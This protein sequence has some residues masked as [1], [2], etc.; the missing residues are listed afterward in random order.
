MKQK[1]EGQKFHIP[2]PFSSEFFMFLQHGVSNDKEVDVYINEKK[3]FA[4]LYPPRAIDY[5]TYESRVKKLNLQT[6]KKKNEVYEKRFVKLVHLFKDNVASLLEVGAAEGSFL[7][8]IKREFPQMDVSAVEP[9][10]STLASRQEIDGIKTYASIEESG[11]IGKRFD[12]IC[13]FHVFEHIM[14]PVKFLNSIKKL[15]HQNTLLIIEVP[16]LFDPLLTL[17]NCLSYKSF[18]FQIQ[19]PYVYSHTSLPRFM[20]YNGFQTQE[21]INFQRYGIENH[22]N[23]LINNAPGGNELYR[24]IF[25]ETNKRYI[26]ELEQ[27]GKTDTV[28]WVGKVKNKC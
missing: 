27:S 12:V 16:S 25:V 20:D 14:D 9:D 21:V 1:I 24:N 28:I 8:I 6:Y 7:F 10:A 15:S 23:W 5:V 19:H 18:Y 13:F 26:E 11:K 22:L 4:F 2:A 17:Y 3:D